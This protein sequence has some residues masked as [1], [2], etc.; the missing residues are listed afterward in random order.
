MSGISEALEFLHNNDWGTILQKIRAH[1]VPG[2]IQF[3]IYAICGG[4]A[5]VVYVGTSL[6][7]CYKVFPAMQGM[8]VNGAP[9]TDSLRARNALINNCIAFMVANVVAYV[10]NV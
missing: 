9:I 8:V 2:L 7:L 6:Y 4:L 10:T 1:D 5:T 3:G